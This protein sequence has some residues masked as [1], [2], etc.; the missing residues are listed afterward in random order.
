MPRLEIT[1]ETPE[2][3]LGRMVREG[4]VV[5]ED[6]HMAE[7]GSMKYKLKTNIPEDELPIFIRD[8]GET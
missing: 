5:I 6:M 4:K 3:W 7:D 2:E 8:E 1:T